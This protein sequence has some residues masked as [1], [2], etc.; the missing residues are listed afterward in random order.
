MAG[1]IWEFTG[2]MYNTHSNVMFFS[3]F[4]CYIVM[5]TNLY[6]FLLRPALVSNEMT[7]SFCAYSSLSRSRAL[8]RPTSSCSSSSRTAGTATGTGT[9][10]VTVIVIGAVLEVLRAATTADRPCT[11]GRACRHRWGRPS[12]ARPAWG[13]RT[14]SGAAWV[15]RVRVRCH[16][17]ARRTTARPARRRLRWVTATADRPARPDRRCPPWDRRR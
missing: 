7:L 4:L 11:A 8:G 1:S 14:T 6:S 13:R 5:C 3:A 2:L 9:V 10:T 12:W 17:W 16:R 15:R